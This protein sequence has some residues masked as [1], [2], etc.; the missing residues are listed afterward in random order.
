MPPA[1]GPRR[2]TIVSLATMVAAIA[3]V[4]LVG[5][6]APEIQEDL[7]FGDAEQGLAIGVFFAVSALF[8]SWGGALTDRVGPSPALRAAAL[9]SAIGATMLLVS[10]GYGVLVAGLVIAAFGNAISQPGNNTFIAGGV[11]PHR[12]GL[13]L[14]IKQAAIPTSTGLA[15]LAL[16]TLAVTLGWR[17]AYAAA[18]VLALG[19]MVAVP[20]IDPPVRRRSEDPGF[21][22][23]RRLIL[24]A[25]GSAAGAAAVA[26]LGAFL[27]R[28]ARDAGFSDTSAGLLQV[29]GSVLL[30]STR[31]G[32]GWLMDHR[33]LDRF[34][35]AAMLLGVGAVAFPLL[36]SG[37]HGLMVLGALLAFGAGWSWPGIVHLGTVETNPRSTGAAS[38]VVQTGMFTG[39]MIG[40]ALFGLVADS[41]GFGWAWMLSCGFSTLAMLLVGAGAVGHQRA[42]RS[43]LAGHL[44]DDP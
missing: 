30:I 5:A 41:H 17:W 18:I 8:S 2:V 22:P 20:T 9:A 19:A 39:A 35:F 32:W 43:A 33:P 15:G 26:S 25:G 3:P 34:R 29:A 23:T 10:P 38:G 11:P 13:A 14:G 4:H 7:G 12:R 42:G 40:P 16:P 6:L 24:V 28:S 37:R 1:A 31:I 21:R 36:A 44:R 27:V